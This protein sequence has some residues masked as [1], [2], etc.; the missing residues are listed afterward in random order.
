[1]T[2]CITIMDVAQALE[3]ALQV[4][5]FPIQINLR[6]RMPQCVLIAL[7]RDT[8]RHNGAVSIHILLKSLNVRDVAMLLNA[9]SLTEGRKVAR[10]LA[11]LLC[12]AQEIGVLVP[13]GHSGKTPSRRS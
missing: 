6:L 11:T 12:Y 2:D 10:Q 13:Y 3:C 7:F 8:L 5:G 4:Q 1:M 9:V